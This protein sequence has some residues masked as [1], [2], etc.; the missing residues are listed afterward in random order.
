M[1]DYLLLADHRRTDLLSK[2]ATG[3]SAVLEEVCGGVLRGRRFLLHSGRVYDKPGSAEVC[4]C[5]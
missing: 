3:V 1:L 4:Q 2:S 5:A